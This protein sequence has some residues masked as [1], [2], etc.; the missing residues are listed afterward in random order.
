MASPASPPTRLR[1]LVARLLAGVT[2]AYTL[3]LVLA[4]HYPRPEE[5]LGPRPPSDKTLHFM[6]YGALAVLAAGTLA[7]AKRWSARRAALLA[8][9]LAAFAAVDEV[10]QPLFSRAAEWLDWVYDGIGIAVGLA[11]IALAVIAIRLA[12]GADR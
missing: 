11:V 6:A 5:F 3:V 2:A 8:G 4:T 7:L 12:R 9:G 1:G 10:T